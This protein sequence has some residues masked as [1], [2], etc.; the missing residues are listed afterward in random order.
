MTVGSRC[1]LCRI[2]RL[3]THCNSWGCP[4]GWLRCPDHS[5]RAWFDVRRH[6]AYDRD[7]RQLVW[8]EPEATP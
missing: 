8:P 7:F 2:G 1:P 5:C 4:I 3:V 6:A